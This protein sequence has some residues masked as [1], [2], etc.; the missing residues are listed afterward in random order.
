[1]VRSLPLEIVSE[2]VSRM[3]VEREATLRG[4]V[5]DLPPSPH[6]RVRRDRE[7]T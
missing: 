2:A 1:M 7:E 5:P 3:S 6:V 4:L